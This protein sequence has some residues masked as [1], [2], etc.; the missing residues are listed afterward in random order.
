MSA[1]RRRRD[2]TRLSDWIGLGGWLILT[3]AAAAIGS[4]F[5]PGLWYDQLQ[6][7]PWTPPDWLFG[8]VWTVLYALMAIAAWLVWKERRAV[9][10]PVALG[11]F[12]VQLAL[13][14]VWSWL[15]FGLQRPDLALLDIG[16]LW[17]AILGTILAFRTVRPVAAWLLVPYLVWVSFAALLNFEIWRLNPA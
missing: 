13:N 10:R 5:Q 11:L 16:L 4:R 15:F 1:A 7:P 2:G 8:P 14:V 3:F 9:Q 12:G 17:L 6:K